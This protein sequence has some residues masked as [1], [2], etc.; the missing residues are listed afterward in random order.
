MGSWRCRTQTLELH[1]LKQCTDELKGYFTCS[2]SADLMT[3]PYVL[4]TGQMYEAA[5]IRQW[6]T[7]RNTCP[8]TGIQLKAWD[9]VA[10]VSVILRNV[11]AVVARI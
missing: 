2:I 10:P 11:C 9:H 1:R 4:S 6:L 8:N 7:Q 3:Q 5:C